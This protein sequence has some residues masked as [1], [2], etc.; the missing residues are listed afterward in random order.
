MKVRSESSLFV[1]G[2]LWMHPGV[3]GYEIYKAAGG[4]ENK[5][6]SG[7]IHGAVKRLS[8]SRKICTDRSVQPHKYYHLDYY[9]TFKG[10]STLREFTTWL[11]QFPQDEGVRI[12]LGVS[13]KP[14]VIKVSD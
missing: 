12:Y 9:G 2:Y 8:A 4:M 7:K 10:V 14:R 13:D 1:L 3:T 11:S 6:L 5:E